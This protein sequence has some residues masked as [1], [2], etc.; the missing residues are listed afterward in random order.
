[1][2]RNHQS[3]FEMWA[4][5]QAENRKL[6]EINQILQEALRNSDL[7]NSRQYEENVKLEHKIWEL[8]QKQEPAEGE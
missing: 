7:R 3:Y 1:M 2:S 6:K 5:S 8:E 4:R